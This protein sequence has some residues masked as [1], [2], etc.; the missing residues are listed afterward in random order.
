MS[1]GQDQ[2]S[3]PM[4]SGSALLLGIGPTGPA[5]LCCPGVAQGPLSR[6][7][8]KMRGRARSPALVTLGPTLPP[9]SGTDGW[10]SLSHLWWH[11]TD[12]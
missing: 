5:L 8:Q 12:E 2:F 6:E 11:M 9:A 7:P 10:P 4:S 1:K 3:Y